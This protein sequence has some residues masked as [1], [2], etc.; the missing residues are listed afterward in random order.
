MNTE[1]NIVRRSFTQAEIL[2]RLFYPMVNEGARIL[3]EGIAARASDVD[4]IWLNGYNWPA[5]TGGPMC[6]A[7][8]TGL[9]R[10]VEAL[11]AFHAETRDENLKP[12]GLLRQFA[13]EGRG[14]VPERIRSAHLEGAD[15]Y[16]SRS[17]SLTRT[18]LRA[19]ASAYS[20]GACAMPLRLSASAIRRGRTCSRRN[21]GVAIARGAPQFTATGGSPPP[22]RKPTARALDIAHGQLIAHG[23]TPCP[24]TQRAH[25]S[26]DEPSG[27]RLNYRAPPRSWQRGAC[28]VDTF[29]LLA[30]SADNRGV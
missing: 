16:A 15:Q 18:I 2:A 10:I 14:F 28:P 1:R 25:A 7:H 26:G 12:V 11:D 21:F 5:T 27:E 29:P 9:S 4:V 22:G 23:K 30:R 17:G 6:W 24:K 3:E 8:G 19:D 20:S 13:S